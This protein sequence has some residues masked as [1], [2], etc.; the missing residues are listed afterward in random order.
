MYC[1]IFLE[2]SLILNRRRDD[3]DRDFRH[4]K[5]KNKNALGIL[6]LES[7]QEPETQARGSLRTDVTPM[8]Y[9]CATMWHETDT[10]MIQ[11][12]TSI[13]R[14]DLDQCTR[15][16]AYIFFDVMDPDY[17]EFEAHIFFD[18]A[19]ESHDDEEFEY[20]ANAFVKQL[21]SVIDRAASIVHRVQVKMDDPNKY[22]TPYGGRLEWHLPGQNK[23]ICH[24]KDKAKIRHRKR[25]SQV[26][27]MYYLL[28]HRLVGQPLPDA[29]RKQ[30][31]ADNTYILTLDGD[32]DFK[33]SAVQL[34]VDRMKKNEKV[35]AACGRIHPI[36]TG[37]MVWYQKFEYA[38]SHWLQKATE[39]MIGCVM[40]SPGCFSLFRGS[41]I[42][43]DNVM[44]KYA[45]LSTEAAHYVQY[46]QG[47]D[48]WLCTLLLQQGYRVE[49]CAAADA[50]TYCPESFNEFFN[51]RRRW[52]P[53]TMANIMDF[54]SDWRNMI[55]KNENIS[56]MYVLYQLLLF[57]SSI[58]TPGTTFLL[59]VGAINMAFPTLD[60]LDALLAN[61]AP[62]CLF[63]VI[64]FVA[65]SEWQLR[66]AAILS[67]V[68][69]L[70][71]MLV[72]VGL[73]LSVKTEGICAPATIF[74][75]FLIAVF[76]ISAIMHP[77]EFLNIFY[78]VLYVL[79]IPSMSMLLMI[80][81]MCNLHVV[82]W[83]TR[84]TTTAVTVNQK[85]SKPS[86]DGRLQSL[87]NMF[88]SN[89]PE[90]KSEYGFSFGNLFRC[91]CCPRTVENTDEVR[92]S[93]ILDK[94]SKIES[95]V[96]AIRNGYQ[97]VPTTPNDVANIAEIK[98]LN[99]DMA[100]KTATINGEPADISKE[101]EANSTNDLSQSVRTN[102][103]DDEFSPYWLR[104]NDIGEGRVRYLSPEE[105][106]FWKDL[107]SKYLFPLEN[108]VEHQ[109]K[110]KAD[111][112]ELRNKMCL[113]FYLLNALFIV[114]IFTLQYT[115]A[116]QGGD[117]L[118]IPLPCKTVDGSRKLSLEPISMV[119]MAVFGVSL[120]IQ[121]IAMFFHRMS[122][123]LHIIASTDVNC[124]KMNQS[125][126]AAMDISDKLELVRQMQSYTEDDDTKSISSLGSCDSIEDDS[127]ITN[128]DSPKPRRRK[129]VMRLTKRRRK[130]PEQ[131][132][133][134]TS[135]FMSRYLKLANDLKKERLS[136]S[137][138]I[139]NGIKKDSSS[140]KKRKGSFKRSDRALKKLEQHKSAVL[141]KAQ[142]FQR[143][144]GMSNGENAKGDPWFKMMKNA[145]T[146][147]RSS[148]NTIGEED[149]KYMSRG[150]F[151]RSNSLDGSNTL[152]REKITEFRPS[153]ASF[154]AYS[155]AQLE[156]VAEVRTAEHFVDID[157]DGSSSS[158]KE[159]NSS[160][161]SNEANED[162]ELKDLGDNSN[163]QKPTKL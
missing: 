153:R 100:E 34:L 111:L 156:S 115:N 28:G 130:P 65:K 15:K 161:D 118:A 163:N 143:Y 138:D 41:A 148:L 53:S 67:G 21:V 86:K 139:S 157:M 75:I 127:S 45:T 147:S 103:L 85:N 58:V 113:M 44:R 77:M 6:Q 159:D 18:D 144:K 1:G 38:V 56:W 3:K 123:F 33:P 124:L 22:P 116:I 4:Y 71:M 87:L 43:D 112:K 24:M 98:S 55:R 104:D 9:V 141:T 93:V 142:K 106:R 73:A 132:G 120:L 13:F 140:K 81:S 16:H 59:I 7:D 84:E 122:T 137:G 2:Q 125:E 32:V 5:E 154:G 76:S 101:Q 74:I 10:E 99:D 129:T 108:N 31:I 128:D 52:S 150:K 64:C 37:P 102:Q 97:S 8:L 14:L 134:L 42:M 95:A 117:G 39:H 152:E 40:C 11:I 57:F 46:D 149:H 160:L 110:M 68:Y 89:K 23:L 49:Y 36:G 136:E 133:N 151:K 35:G 50:Y 20:Q 109:K 66:M 94:L 60:L 131:S 62:I 126:I 119:F 30:T 135:K 92:F 91:M 29:R 105:I 162:I 78:G 72:V 80:Y 25:W 158:V 88:S 69:A 19:F 146:T 48:R 155:P 121:F 26:M 12:L 17:Y 107:I 82:T 79:A 145:L 51:Q 83:G 90:L 27:Y 96:G 114:I 61:L 47:E 63:M 70:V 54:L